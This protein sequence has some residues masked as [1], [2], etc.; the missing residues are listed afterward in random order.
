MPDTTSRFASVPAATP[1]SATTYRL[2]F[3]RVI[4]SEWIRLVSTRTT[5]LTLL[6]TGAVMAAVGLIAASVS[7][8][9]TAQLP[10]PGPGFGSTDPMS[11]LMAG[12]TPAFLLVAVLGVIV[13][14]REYG[15]GLA[16]TTYAA[17]PRR[18]PVLAARLLVLA[19]AAVVVISTGAV[20]ALIGGNALLSAG[21]APTV[22]WSDDGAVRALFG[23]V[24]YLVGT[25]L[26]GVAVGTLTRSVGSGLG[27]VLGIGLV[28][29]AF[30]G[31]LLPEDWQDALNYLP[32]QQA[33]TSF[34]ALDAG[35]T[36]LSVGAGAVVFFAWV[37][38]TSL[39]AAAA[40]LRR[41]I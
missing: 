29:P 34:T 6:V 14:A 23:T 30:G 26:I 8:G 4:R 7:T 33:A 25:A 2:T 21:D 12:A 22:A 38:T 15:T 10:S 3:G 28:L 5:C 27:F 31:L 17:V 11:T 36:Y 41:D 9:D 35:G 16:R 32:S 20:I 24:G 1:D 37:A 40:V 13:G 19:A 18:W 39:A